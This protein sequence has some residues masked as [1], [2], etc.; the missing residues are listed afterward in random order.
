MFAT[1][2][3]APGFADIELEGSSER[4]W[5]GTDADDAHQFVLGLLGW[6]L[7]DLD[8]NGRALALDALRSTIAAHETPDG[9]IF[10]SAIWVIRATCPW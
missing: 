8:D 9:V 3:R 5:F 10:D 7:E 4:M 6:M 2:S 1:F